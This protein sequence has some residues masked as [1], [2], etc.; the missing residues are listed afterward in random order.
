MTSR[1][2]TTTSTFPPLNSRELDAIS[3]DK[4][5]RELESVLMCSRRSRFWHGAW[6]VTWT[7]ALLAAAAVVPVLVVDMERMALALMALSGGFLLGSRVCGDRSQYF[8]DRC[9]TESQ[10]IMRLLK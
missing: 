10:R 3:R 2:R 4:Y 1:R 5:R 6:R 8:F 7:L 9:N